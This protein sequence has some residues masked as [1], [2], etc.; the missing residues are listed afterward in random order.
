MRHF[1]PLMLVLLGLFVLAPSLS[2][3]AATVQPFT[4]AA[5]EAAQARNQ[6]IL[7]DIWA[8]WCPICAAQKPIIERLGKSP[9]F[10]DLLVLRVNFDTQKAIVRAMGA[11]MQSTL[12][13][14]H[15]RKLVGVT[16]GDT[17]PASIAALLEKTIG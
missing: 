14:F 1:R 12:I 7:V 16:V 9:A 8:S 11:R 4:K 5:F 17:D 15:G 10:H 13:A 3:R 2:A 6:P